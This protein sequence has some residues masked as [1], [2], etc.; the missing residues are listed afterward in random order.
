[1]P[2]IEWLRRVQIPPPF[3]ITPPPLHPSPHDTVES[4][5]SP[6]TENL[7]HPTSTPFPTTRQNAKP[8]SNIKQS[9]CVTDMFMMISVGSNDDVDDDD[10][11]D[12]MMKNRGPV[13]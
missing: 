2:W 4:V 6:S 8:K 11:N 12:A 9:L 7:P 5:S 1:M 10:N 3:P 13:C